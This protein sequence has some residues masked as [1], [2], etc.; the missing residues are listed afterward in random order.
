MTGGAWSRWV[1]CS[2]SPSLHSLPH[3][4]V[5]PSYLTPSSNLTHSTANLP[6][7]TPPTTPSFP[8]SI[9]RSAGRV[10]VV[11]DGRGVFVVGG[12]EEV[13]GLGGS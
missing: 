9:P 11:G 1:G 12:W 3:S 6:P 10:V 7:P 8:P 5:V 4:L 2:F 13:V